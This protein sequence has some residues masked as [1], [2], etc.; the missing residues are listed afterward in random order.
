MTCA[1]RQGESSPTSLIP[2]VFSTAFSLSLSWPHSAFSASVASYGKS[3]SLPQVSYASTASSLSNVDLY[4]YFSR[5]CS[6]DEIQSE[7]LVSLLEYIDLTPFIAVLYRTDLEYSTTLASNFMSRYA[8]VLAL[9]SIDCHLVGE[10]MATSSSLSLVSV[11][12]SQ[13]S[14][15]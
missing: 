5:T 7:R 11:Q 13:T 8:L 12:A 1:Q 3:V 2:T 4:P 15:A 9:V 14:T 6:S 10:R